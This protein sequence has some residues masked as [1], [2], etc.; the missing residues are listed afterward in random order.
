VLCADGQTAQQRS[1]GLRSEAVPFF[2]VEKN[3]A[4]CDIVTPAPEGAAG[5]LGHFTDQ[6]AT[7]GSDAKSS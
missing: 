4:S 6:C 5:L 3:L 1:A 2:V 7:S